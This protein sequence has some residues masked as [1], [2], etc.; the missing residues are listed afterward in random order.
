MKKTIILIISILILLICVGS[1]LCFTFLT[2]KNSKTPFLY[3]PSAVFYEPKIQNSVDL[4]KNQ[5]LLPGLKEVTVNQGATN[6]IFPLFNSKLN[7]VDLV[8][9][10][11]LE[12]QNKSLRTTGRISPGK[13]ILT[14]P[15]PQNL[16]PGKYH[17]KVKIKAY[18]KTQNKKLNGGTI[19][20]VL[21]VEKKGNENF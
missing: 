20:T 6:V 8:F 1:V 15:L 13:A 3:D 18:G 2:N 16:E 9:E 17:L 10:V 12:E 5:I 7:A 21:N 14:V 4:K 19:T 11:I